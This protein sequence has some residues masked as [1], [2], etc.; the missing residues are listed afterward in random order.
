LREAGRHRLGHTSETEAVRIGEHVLDR[1]N[2]LPAE[3]LEADRQLG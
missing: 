1:G 3:E 2:V